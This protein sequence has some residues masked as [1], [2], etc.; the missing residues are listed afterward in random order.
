MENKNHN[1]NQPFKRQS[2][3][4]IKHSNNSSATA[5]EPFECVIPSFEVG[6]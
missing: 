1:L 5:G 3:K 2:H 4:M 6:A